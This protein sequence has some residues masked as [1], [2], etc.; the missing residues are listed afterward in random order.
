VRWFLSAEKGESACQ[1]TLRS[2]CVVGIALKQLR[3]WAGLCRHPMLFTPS[4]ITY[5]F[6]F[7]AGLKWTNTNIGLK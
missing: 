7:Y 3:F 5:C 6:N 4:C 1:V 2:C